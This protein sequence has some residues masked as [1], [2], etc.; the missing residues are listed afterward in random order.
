MQG[1]FEVYGRKRDYVRDKISNTISGH[2]L[3]LKL[4]IFGQILQMI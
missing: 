1:L 4:F 2:I 3:M